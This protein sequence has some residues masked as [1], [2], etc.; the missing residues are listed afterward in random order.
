[1]HTMSIKWLQTLLKTMSDLELS[2]A[3][4]GDLVFL[5]KETSACSFERAVSDVA[6]SPYYHVAI[7]GRD[8]RLLH[9]STRG[10]LSQSMEEFLNE[11][12]P[13]RMEIVH[14]KAP[15]K[16]KRDAAAFAESKVGM[17]YNDIFTPNRINSQ[18]QE[19]YYC[20]Q[21][22][23]EAYDGAVHFPEHKLNFKDKDGDFLEYWLKYYRERGI[24]IPQDDQGSHPASLRRSPLLDMKLTRHLQKKILNCKNVTNALHYIGGAAVRLT[25]GKKF[26][27]IEPRSG[28][29]LAEC[30]AATP[31][32]V[33]R[34]VAT[35]QE[36]QKT[37][38]KM[39][40]LERGLVLRNVAKLLREHCE[41]IARWE[42]IDS[43]KP[44]TEARM[45]VLSCVDT[46]NY[47]G[48]A[49]YSQA[50]QHIPLGIERFAYTKRE[51]LGVVGCIGTWNYPI[52]TCSWKVAPALACG[53]AVVYKPSPLA[54][55][56]AVILAQILQLA[57][58]P[59]G[60]FNVIQG[61]AETGQ[62]LV[63]H[64]L[65]KKVSFTGA[66]PTGK[67]I[68]Q[69]CAARNVKP[70]TLEL[71]GKASLIIFEDADVE[72][73]VAGAMMA[74]FYSQG[75]V[76]TNAS[77]VLVH[78]SLEDNFVASLREKTK[79]MKIGDP[80]EETTRVGAHISREHMEKVKKYI[81][82]AKAAGAR[83]ICGGEPIQVNGLEAG[84]YLSPCIL[85][86][87][88]KD[89]DVYRE[90]IF[91]SVLLIIPFDT[92]EEAIGI[93]N[94]TTLG[95]AAGL[96]TKDLARAHRVA[97]RLH[98]GNVYVNT[99]NDVSPF[100]PFGGYGDSGFGRENGVAALEHYSQ[101]KSVF[102]SIASKL[103]NPFK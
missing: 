33:D 94:D 74:N 12:E 63:L 86:N 66:V 2:Q 87:I 52:Q 49:I 8:K 24:D 32:E 53:N 58:L 85:S 91:G 38:S 75:Q 47:Y 90:E 79:A 62:A 45:D 37:W 43:G 31:D 50:G 19:S 71:G 26:Q 10:V 80:L 78:R 93:A 64:P 51:P 3:C 35:A 34:A 103:E 56:S 46:F 20:S 6:S 81:D 59:E 70:I 11:Y 76:C 102:V 28:S 60:T 42:S 82:G 99:Y 27:V 40:W 73:A 1:M 21:L 29:T 65:V 92:E 98:A 23:T 69:D 22:I 7:I 9:A 39:G 89:M 55:I 84:F 101:I 30:H 77:K 48:G 17:P 13:H 95:L 16:A 18:G 96:F 88:K 44:I 68:M 83:V 54:P 15:E 67:K 25:A 61:D 14:V 41:V 5:A 4:A 100:V 72:S 57:G 36:A 97:D